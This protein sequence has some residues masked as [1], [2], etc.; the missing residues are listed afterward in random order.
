MWKLLE[1]EHLL[2]SLILT[3]KLKIDELILKI[4]QSM[5]TENL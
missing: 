4:G 5:V 3:Y 2:Q 1:I